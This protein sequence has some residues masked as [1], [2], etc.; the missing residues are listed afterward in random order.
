M[1]SGSTHKVTVGGSEMTVAIKTK[2]MGWE[3]TLTVGD[4]EVRSAMEGD[5]GDVPPSERVRATVGSAGL[6]D[7]GVTFY[8][9]ETWRPSAAGGYV[10]GGGCED[11]GRGDGGGD[12]E[13][14]TEGDTARS[15]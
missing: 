9:L 3:F 7:S 2:G 1:D 12:T 10:G 14:D 13:G 15:A 4:E 5:S 6:G 11:K 8:S